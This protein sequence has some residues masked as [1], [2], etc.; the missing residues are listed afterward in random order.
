MS[1]ALLLQENGC[2]IVIQFNVIQICFNQLLRGSL[3]THT[4]ITI[5]IHIQQQQH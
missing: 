4:Q 2:N 5:L 1:K 3:H